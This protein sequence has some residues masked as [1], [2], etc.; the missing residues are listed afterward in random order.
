MHPLYYIFLFFTEAA[1]ILAYC[2]L[3]SSNN[4]FRSNLERQLQRYR[5]NNLSTYYDYTV[6]SPQ[7]SKPLPTKNSQTHTQSRQRIYL[8]SA[9]LLSNREQEVAGSFHTKH[10]HTICSEFVNFQLPHQLPTSQQKTQNNLSANQ[11]LKHK[12]KEKLI[13]QHTL[14]STT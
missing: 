13:T 1:K 3:L 7:I 8:I 9:I 12:E 2:S 4:T 5:K 6:V 14:S 10:K 11:S